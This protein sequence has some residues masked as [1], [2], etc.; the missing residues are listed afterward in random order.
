MNRPKCLTT[1]VFLVAVCSVGFP[2]AYASITSVTSNISGNG[3]YGSLS[4]PGN[5]PSQGAQLFN[6]GCFGDFTGFFE[7]FESLHYKYPDYSHWQRFSDGKRC[8]RTHS[9]T[10][11]L[12][13][14]GPAEFLFFPKKSGIFHT[15]SDRSSMR[16]RFDK[17]RRS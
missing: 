8:C 12:L 13:G 5:F 7:P 3:G 4:Y 2:N 9:L 10:G 11:L 14:S 6:L 16:F 17:R 1:F 15:H